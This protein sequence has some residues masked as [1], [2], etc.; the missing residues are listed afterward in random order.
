[1]NNLEQPGAAVAVIRLRLSVPEYLVL[2]RA[3]NP[4]DPW[5]GHFALP[6]GRRESGDADLLAT[7][8]RET[9]EECGLELQPSHLIRELPPWHAGRATDRS[10]LVAPFLFELEE[11]PELRLDRKE[12]AAFHWVSREY[13]LDKT[14][15]GRHFPLLPASGDGFPGIRLGGGFLWGFTYKVLTGILLEDESR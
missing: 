1:M 15:H 12:I 7:C 4:A 10:T 5:S 11:K 14:N 3:E 6:G 2:K 13:F 8:L 9:R